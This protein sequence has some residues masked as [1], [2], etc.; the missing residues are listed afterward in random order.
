MMRMRVPV[1]EFT[2][3]D[4]IVATEDMS[5][6]EMQKLMQEH[7]IRHLPV[8]NDA[9]EVVGVISD[10]DIR[11]ILGLSVAEKL[12]VRASDIMT[13]DPVTVSADT[14]LDDVAFTMAEKKVGSVIVKDEKGKF[15]GIFT[16]TD[17]LNAL[18]EIIRSGGPGTD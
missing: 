4:P 1:V 12:L 17:A 5:V 7:G 8:V 15:L 14:P 6:D 3:P 9:G 10:R 11:V 2:T 18:V 13:T 16:A